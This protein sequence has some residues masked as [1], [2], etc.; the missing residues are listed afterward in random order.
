VSEEQTKVMD[1]TEGC[2]HQGVSTD[3]WRLEWL[4]GDGADLTVRYRDPI[5]QID[6][7]IVSS[8]RDRRLPVPQKLFKIDC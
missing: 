2:S 4:D 1:G 7:G 6:D 3:G 8:F 5:K